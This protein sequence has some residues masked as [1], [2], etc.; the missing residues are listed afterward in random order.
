[1][2]LNYIGVF[3][4][5][6]YQGKNYDRK[7]HHTAVVKGKSVDYYEVCEIDEVNTDVS[8]SMAKKLNT[9]ILETEAV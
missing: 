9:L 8:L 5:S 7:Y 4:S 2:T 3:P 6:Q 1:M